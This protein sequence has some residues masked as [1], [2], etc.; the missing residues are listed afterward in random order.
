M[1]GIP[2]G[3]YV[4]TVA[5]PSTE[6]MK[7]IEI[8]PSPM[9]CLRHENP[10]GQLSGMRWVLHHPCC[11]ITTGIDYLPRWWFQKVGICYP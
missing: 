8:Y 1:D 6:A 2:H 3:M 5:K 11:Y 10:A 7:M 4:L 9:G